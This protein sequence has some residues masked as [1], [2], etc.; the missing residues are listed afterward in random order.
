MTCHLISRKRDG[1][2]DV[3]VSSNPHVVGQIWPPII[4][5]LKEREMVLEKLALLVLARSLNPQSSM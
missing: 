1:C 5:K 3:N 2:Y 4:T